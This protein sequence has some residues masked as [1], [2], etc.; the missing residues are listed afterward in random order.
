MGKRVA[1][2]TPEQRES[3][4]EYRRRY[5]EKYPD[6][7]RAAA[8]AYRSEN[9]DDL[10]AYDRTR[11]RT[12]DLIMRDQNDTLRALSSRSGMPWE[13]WEDRAVLQHGLT[14]YQRARLVGRTL[15]AVIHRRVLLD[16]IAAEA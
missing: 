11:S 3:A 4:R 5:R 16:R 8:R 2:M 15:Y 6:R 10:I 7:V 14:N 1:D 9:R 13:P 12:P